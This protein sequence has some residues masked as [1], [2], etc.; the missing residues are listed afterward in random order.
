[1]PIGGVYAETLEALNARS[2]RPLNIASANITEILQGS[3][4]AIAT[5]ATSSTEKSPTSGGFSFRLAACL[6]KPVV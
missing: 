3:G 2:T 1:M 5:F 4:L 6:R